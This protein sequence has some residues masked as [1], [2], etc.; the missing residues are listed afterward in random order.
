MTTFT[1]Y[2]PTQPA[3]T[4]IEAMLAPSSGL[5]ISG[6]IVLKASGANAVNFYAN[7]LADLGIG[8]GLL[9]TSGTTPGTTNTVGWFGTDNS[10]WPDTFYNGDA[11]IDA[12]VNT[13]FQTQSYDATT[14]EFDV[15]A[16]ASATS[17]SFDLVFGSDEY[18]EWVDQFVDCAIFMVN[19]VNYALFNHDA[20]HPLSVVSANLAAGYFQDNG[21]NVLPIEYDG[22]SHVL[23]IVAPITPGAVNHIKIGIA[24]TGDHIYDSGIFITNLAAGNIPGSGVVTTSP[25]NCTDGADTVTG[26]AKD[27]YFDLKGGDDVVYAGAGDDIVV[28]GAGMDKVFGGSGQDQ[29]KGDQGDDDIDGGDGDD[30]AVYAGASSAYTVTYDSA[31]ASYTVTDNAGPANEGV[32]TLKSV[33]YAKFSNGLFMLGTGGL[34][35]VTAPGPAP[36]NTPGLVIVSGIGAT[37]KTL[38]ATVS[39]ADGV[40]GAVT[41][42]WQVSGNGG[43]T[44]TDVGTDSAQYDVASGDVGM[45]IQVV[46]NYADGDGTAESP[47][48][49]AKLIQASKPGDL[50][51]TLMKLDAPLGASTINPLTTLVQNAIELGLSPNTAVQA[52]KTVLGLSD[53]IKLQSY[54]AYAVLQNNPADATALQVEKI[55]VQVAILTSL[56]DD[57]QGTGLTLAILDAAA[58]KQTLDLGDVNDLSAILGIPAVID[59][60]T[61]KYPQ[62]LAEIWD[63]NKTLSEAV[64]DGGDVAVIEKEWHDL[65]T[66]QT[67]IASTSIAD[68]SIHVNQAPTGSAAAALADGT[69]DKAYLITAADLLTGFADPDGDTLQVA[70]LAADSGTLQGNADGT[71]TFTPAAGFSGPVELSYLVQDG[72]GGEAAA[73][74]LFVVAA[75]GGPVDKEATGMLLVTGT[76]AE[77]G[78]L[79]ADLVNAGDADGSFIVA[80]QWQENLDGAWTDLGVLSGDPLVIPDD[81]SYVGRQ[82]R[83]VATTT[84]ALGGTTAF[85]SAGQF[86]VNVNDVHTGTVGISGTA[87]EGQTLTAGNNLADEDGLGAIQY[88]WQS[89]GTD[90]A[91]AQGSTLTLTSSL[92]GQAIAVKASY[93]DGFGSVETETSAAT[94]TVAALPTDVNLVGT[95]AADTLTGGTGD[96]TLAGLAGNDKLSGLSGNDVL[97]GGAGLDVLDG[98]EGSDI[99]LVSLSSDHGKAE[100][101]D[102]G[103]VGLDEVRFAASA[104][105]T[106]TLYS[107]DTGIE[108]VVIGTGVG[109]S[110]DTTG[111]TALNVNA[112]AVGNALLVVGNAGNNSLTGTSRS[113]TLEGGDGADKLVGGGGDDSLIGGLGKDTLTGGVGAD[114]FVFNTPANASTNLDTI[115][116]FVHLAD[117]LQFSAAAFSA[118]GTSWTAAQF[119]SAPGAT[120]GHDADDRLVYN[121]STGSLYY[122]A[123]GYGGEAAVQVA[124]IG[125]SKTHPI[126]DWTDIQVLA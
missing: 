97:D 41:Y 70:G 98:G 47:V 58:A 89:N 122:D 101:K 116:D 42:Q 126:V 79:V 23:K 30:T 56:S 81:Q 74:Q 26:S 16:G 66:I 44:W 124:L 54:D 9:L 40:G 92:V 118:L 38:T 67:G 77:G 72:Q 78:L 20:N 84:D 43:A 55:A 87:L 113:D 28:A 108:R 12:V 14:L 4:L 48:S 117:K 106:L 6:P 25:G 94:A 114:A 71:W 96:D 115:T 85:E 123:D 15:T 80:Y 69:Q 93:T 7:S 83:V 36:T 18:P 62:P 33:E 31:S 57:D 65:L 103:L 107:G 39:D 49:A 29:I 45:M 50:A 24:D 22:V 10:I 21:G 90:I 1:V 51:V 125:T 34:T 32:D 17:V 82:V 63:R 86:I 105:S 121:S 13:V 53:A 46:A 64:A 99:Y 109:A 120:G 27:E 2:V 104:S 119:W 61:G 95:S 5:T 111:T 75:S 110:A 52:I 37:G 112:S 59:P 19:G 76:P 100:F 68:L 60:G 73:S 3:S 91:G 88:Q 8:N 35:P 11:D 102:T